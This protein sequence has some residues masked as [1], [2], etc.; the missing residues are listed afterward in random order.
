MFTKLTGRFLENWLHCTTIKSTHK[1]KEGTIPLFQISQRETI[2][3]VHIPCTFILCKY[4][5]IIS[6]NRKKTR[7]IRNFLSLFKSTT[8]SCANSLTK[9]IYCV[10]L[11]LWLIFVRFPFGKYSLLAV[12]GS[13]CRIA[14]VVKIV[15]VPVVSLC[16]FGRW[17]AGFCI[18]GN[19]ILVVCGF[20]Y[21]THT[22]QN[23]GNDFG[24]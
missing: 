20:C 17:S 18:H 14:H 2:Q 4:S 1:I 10:N 19:G 22:I 5:L 21:F 24:S 12:S 11:I 13:K 15:F 16:P 3:R 7:E 9:P 23:S 6:N 8:I